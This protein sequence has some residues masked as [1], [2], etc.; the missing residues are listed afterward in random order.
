LGKKREDVAWIGGKAKN[1]CI[2]ICIKMFPEKVV[3]NGS[4]NSNKGR[5]KESQKIYHIWKTLKRI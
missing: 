4:C 5:D 2:Q 1:D 3:D